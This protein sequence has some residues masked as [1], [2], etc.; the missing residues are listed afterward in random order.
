MS[1]DLITF[2]FQQSLRRN[3]FA[4]SLFLSTESLRVNL[5]LGHHNHGL[6]LELFE[7]SQFALSGGDRH[8]CLHK[9]KQNHRV[10]E[11][12]SEIKTILAW[13]TVVSALAK[14]ARLTETQ[15]N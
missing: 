7:L 12:C 8:I 4:L 2:H 14:S 6:S 1:Q 9:E 5:L 15:S 11:T 3:L 13:V 10:S